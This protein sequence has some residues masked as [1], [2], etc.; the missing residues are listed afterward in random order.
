MNKPLHEILFHYFDIPK[1]ATVY[2]TY[3]IKRNRFFL[4]ISPKSFINDYAIG[5]FKQDIGIKTLDD[6]EIK[7]ILPRNVQKDIINF[8][9]KT[10]EKHKS[11]IKGNLLASVI[12]YKNGIAVEHLMDSREFTMLN[13][14]KPQFEFLTDTDNYEESQEKY[15]Q[16]IKAIKENKKNDPVYLEAMEA[17][18]K[19]IAKDSITVPYGKGKKKTLKIHYETMKDT[20]SFYYACVITSQP[21]LRKGFRNIPVAEPELQLRISYKI[22]SLPKKVIDTVIAHEL[23]HAIRALNQNYSS[24]YYDQSEFWSNFEE[25]MADRGIK[26]QLP[27]VKEMYRDVKERKDALKQSHKILNARWLLTLGP[28]TWL[29]EWKDRFTG[30]SSMEE[31]LKASFYNK[32]FFRNF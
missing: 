22:L 7:K 11:E 20:P 16:L 26:E 3:N 30:F 1:N 8:Y 19:Y 10:I 4:T 18:K 23:T 15:K 25:F 28:I 27:L 32:L 14:S 13:F 17:L 2:F 31:Y 5:L 6:S 24:M 9:K 21:L 12:K 29:F